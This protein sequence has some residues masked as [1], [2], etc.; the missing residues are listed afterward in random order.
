MQSY[1]T[2]S[3]YLRKTFNKKIVKL[4]VDGGFTCPNRINGNTGCLFCSEKASGEFTFSDLSIKEQLIRQMARYKSINK[5]NE[6]TGYIAYFQNF[7]NTYAS[8]DILSKK[9]DEALSVEQIEGIAIATRPDCIDY[10]I[11]ELLE[12]YNKKTNLWIE[13]GFQTANEKTSILINRGYSN[14]VLTECVEQLNKRSIKIVIHVIFGLPYEEYDD[15]IETIKF[16]KSLNVWGIKLHSLYIQKD[17][18]L[19]KYYENNPFHII[20]FNEYTDAVCEAIK[21]LENKIVIHRLTGDC[22]KSELYEPKWS[23]DKLKVISTINR[24]L[25]I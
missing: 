16:V 9:Y 1:P 6:N 7:S 13:L 20:T 12:Y 17:T 24:K 5:S 11:S 8:S 22:V 15:Y 19:H 14:K 21:I 3:E 2:I 10:K 4:P 23:L 18:A 25:S